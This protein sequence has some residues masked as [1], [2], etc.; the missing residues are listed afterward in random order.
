MFGRKRDPLDG[1]WTLIMGRPEGW[2]DLPRIVELTDDKPGGRN[3]TA[4]SETWARATAAQLLTEVAG[5]AADGVAAPSSE[6]LAEQLVVHLRYAWEANP[7][8]CGLFVPY[9]E[10]GVEGVTQVGPIDP[11]DDGD[12]L[13]AFRRLKEQPWPG[14]LKPRELREVDLPLGPALLVHEVF[15][16]QDPGFPAEVVEGVAYYCRIEQVARF[17]ALTVQW[18]DLSLGDDLQEHAEVMAES[19]QF[20]PL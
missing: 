11:P 3:A 7:M 18:H 10:H 15:Q 1:R 13:A 6:A 5:D 19:M 16:Q 12:D 2:L 8:Y 17:V 14:L 9:P 20:Q 4:V